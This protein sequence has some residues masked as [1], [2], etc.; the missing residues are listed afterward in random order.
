MQGNAELL[1]FIYQN[2][3]MGVI[4][5]KQLLE[6]CEDAN[7]RRQMQSQYDE[8]EAIHRAADQLL[9]QNGYDEKGIGALE[10]MKTYLMINMQTLTDKS[11]SHI[12]EMM[13]VGS[14]MGI[15]QALR[16][17]R[18]Y[19]DAEPAGRDLMQRLLKFEEKNVTEIKQ[20]I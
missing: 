2:S 5:I 18:K 20:F 1:N 6:F 4:T 19:Q 11:S 16:N 12:A 8:Y 3:Q 15:I 14:T 17:L 10:K 9:R 13:T 7:F